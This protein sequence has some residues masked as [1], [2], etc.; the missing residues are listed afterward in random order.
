M[1]TIHDWHD[2]Y[3]YLNVHDS[4]LE[5]KLAFLIEDNQL[6]YEFS[7]QAVF[8]EG[9]L[10]CVEGIEIH[11]SKTQA[12]QYRSGRPEVKTVRYSYHALRREGERTIDILRYD[13]AHEHEG[14]WFNHHKHLFDEDGNEIGSPIYVGEE[15]W[16]TLGAVILEVFN[17]TLD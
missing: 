16:P 5:N 2:W 13:N 1:G 15:G 6:S 14:G 11:V 10:H 4:W 9:I 3:D 7:E 8:W 12:V 17:L